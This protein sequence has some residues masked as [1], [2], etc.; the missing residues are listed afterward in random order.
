M[1]PVSG[2][3]SRKDEMTAY[4]WKWLPWA[5]FLATTLPA[6]AVFLVLL[7]GASSPDTVAFY[8][9]LAVV[10]LGIGALIG[11][12][13][14]LGLLF[15]RRQWFRKLRN[16]LAQDG[17]T[18]T[19][20]PWFMPELTSAERGSLAEIKSQ[21]PLLADAYCE[22]LAT[23]LTAT[24]IITRTRTEQLKVERRL[25]RARSLSGSV[26]ASLLQDLQKDH[27]QLEKL[28]NDATSQLAE[29][30]ARL[31]MIEAAASRSLN[32]NETELMV[33][34]LAESQKQVPLAVE[35]LRMEQEARQEVGLELSSTAVPREKP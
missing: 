14:L 21:N 11:I 9:A 15:L 2:K 16:R 27:E 24:R 22:T 33:R 12:V 1:Q 4:V 23:R 34:R 5:V 35:L 8:L 3:L 6:P 7:I 29:A 10:S 28:R 17:I 20:I 18:A 32:Q 26:T 25:N 30:K 19:E 13:L 31:Q